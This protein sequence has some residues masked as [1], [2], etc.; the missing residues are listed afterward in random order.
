MVYRYYDE[1]QPPSHIDLFSSLDRPAPGIITYST[2][3]LS[4]YDLGLIT[5]EGKKIRA[6]LICLGDSSNPIFANILTSCAFAVMNDHAPCEPGATFDRIISL[7]DDGLEMKYVYLTTPWWLENP[8]RIEREDSVVL[9]LAALPISEKEM[10]YLFQYGPD[11]FEDILEKAS[12]DA[13][14]LYRGS[15]I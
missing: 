9:W 8:P 13:A 11:A 6:E 15:V 1:R 10:G 7:Y 12:P 4:E 3:G 5:Q 14:D 2:I